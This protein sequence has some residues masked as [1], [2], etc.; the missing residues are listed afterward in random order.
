M[1][2]ERISKGFKDI[3]MTFKVHPLNNDIIDIKNENAIARSVR[4]LVMTLKGEIP[5]QPELGSNANR[6]LFDNM[7]PVTLDLLKDDIKL[8]I[9]NY[10]SRVSLYDVQVDPNYDN[11]EVNVRISYKI[12]GIN[13]LPQQ[14]SFVLRPSR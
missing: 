13:V 5:Y 1:P 11:N 4:N 12:I 6:L 3:S 7:D 14:L 2:V 8:T 10:E 9:E